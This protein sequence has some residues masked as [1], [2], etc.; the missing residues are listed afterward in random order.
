[1]G[2]AEGAPFA[3]KTVIPAQRNRNATVHSA[4]TGTSII[5]NASMNR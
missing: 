1:M 4:A 2:V 5:G 3:T